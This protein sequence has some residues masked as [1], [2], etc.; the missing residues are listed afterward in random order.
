[1]LKLQIGEQSFQFASPED[2]AFALSGKSNPSSDRAAALVRLSDVDL[3]READRF[4]QM[5][6]RVSQ[7]LDQA[8]ANPE[9]IEQF[10]RDLDP[11]LIHGDNDW[12]GFFW[13]LT[14]TDTGFVEY[15][16]IALDLYRQYLLSGQELVGAIFAERHQKQPYLAGRNEPESHQEPKPRQSLSFSISELLGHEPAKAD[17]HRLPKGEPVCLGFGPHQCLGL[18]LGKHKFNLV[19]GEPWLLIDPSG[20]DSR[21]APGRCE[22]GR[23][24]EADIVIYGRYRS[25]S[26]KHL[27]VETEGPGVVRLTDTSSLGTFA[28]L[29]DLW[30]LKN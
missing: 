18:R 1:M 6:Q 28:A 20:S 30:E 29:P 21:V 15:K 24:Q 22:V 12:R 23:H 7:A 19:A 10:L 9:S 5:E 3:I 16:R 8:D 13:A 26:R 2:L 11:S 27:L 17:Y 4:T 14:R 25:V